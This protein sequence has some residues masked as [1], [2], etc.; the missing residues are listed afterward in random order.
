MR[1][2]VLT[3]MHKYAHACMHAHTHRHIQTHTTTYITCTDRHTR[4]H[5]HTPHTHVLLLILG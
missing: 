5:M 4:I 3:N 2:H 1:M